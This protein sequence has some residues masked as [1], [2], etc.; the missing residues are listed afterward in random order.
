[1]S[2]SG[3]KHD[4][5]LVNSGVS[6]SNPFASALGI[7]YGVVGEVMVLSVVVSFGSNGV[8]NGGAGGGVG[9][10]RCNSADDDGASGDGA[11]SSGSSGG[12]GDTR[13]CDSLL[14]PM[15]TTWAWGWDGMGW[16]VIMTN[17]FGDCY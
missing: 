17:Y 8:D 4:I 15:V 3:F 14:V 11:A 5:I 1:M 13:W 2:A 12:R 9:W 16:G 10:W 6:S 7:G